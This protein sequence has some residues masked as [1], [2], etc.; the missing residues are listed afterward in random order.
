MRALLENSLRMMRHH[1]EEEGSS[2]E[3]H[4]KTHTTGEFAAVH[5][6]HCDVHVEVRSR[7]VCGAS[8]F[9]VVDLR[10]VVAGLLLL[11]LSSSEVVQLWIVEVTY[12]RTSVVA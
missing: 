11:L 9:A 12:V 5:H 1:G 3:S 8:S 2:D 7:C 4:N 10:L 6:H